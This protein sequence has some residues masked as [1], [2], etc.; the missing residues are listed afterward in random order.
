MLLRMQVCINL[1]TIFNHHQM[2]ADVIVMETT[3][4]PI[5]VDTSDLGNKHRDE[6]ESQL[7]FAGF[8]AFK[9]DLGA[10]KLLVVGESLAMPLPG[11]NRQ[12]CCATEA[13]PGRIAC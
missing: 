2:C 13:K 5:A 8:I 12:R 6:V 1:L 11:C 10:G 3:D 7:T 9:C 4:S